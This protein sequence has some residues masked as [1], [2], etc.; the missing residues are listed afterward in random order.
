MSKNQSEEQD[1]E[2]GERERQLRE[3]I[4]SMLRNPQSL[5]CIWWI[6]QQ[7]GIYGV[8]FTGDEMTAFREGQRSIGLT[9][10]QKIA[11]VD[12]TAYPTLMLEMSKFEQKIKE[13]EE[14]GKNDDE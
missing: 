14:A 10:I 1:Q 6:L 4:S 11:E 12:E 3:D 9:I 8:S 5:R 2:P 7:C 13:A